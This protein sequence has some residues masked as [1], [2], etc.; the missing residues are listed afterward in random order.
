MN[1]PMIQAYLDEGAVFYCSHSG[2][3]DSQ[4]M[5]LLLDALVP[6]H[7]LSVVHADLGEVEWLGT[8]DHIR[9]TT[10]H[11]VH[12]VHAVWKDG[13]RKH[14]LDMV[15]KRAVD[16]PDV[17]SWP[18]SSQ[19]YCTSDLKRGPIEKFIRADMKSR[20]A[21]LAVNCMGLRA[22]ESPG[23]AKKPVLATNKRLSKA[24]RNVLDWLPVHDW[25]TAQV[26]ESIAAAHQQPHP[27]YAL[28]NDRLS[29]VFCIFGSPGDLQN[30]ADQRPELAAKYLEL[31]AR[32][33][34]T[35]FHKSALAD[36][37]TLKEII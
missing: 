19:R 26:F 31:E 2:G 34:S 30:G 27:A 33:G 16:R 29:C 12:V 7:R 37:I 15:E 5:Y 24:G 13:S 8:Q 36:R 4:A 25:S 23:R 3:K 17:P 21:T 18:S 6:A 20:G 10:R 22:E 35:M 1:H 11:P 9:A 32:T 28:G 14:L